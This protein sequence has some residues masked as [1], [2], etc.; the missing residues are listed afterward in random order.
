MTPVSSAP[1]CPPGQQEGPQWATY[2]LEKAGSSTTFLQGPLLAIP[3]QVR[4]VP[5]CS[6]HPG[7]A[8]AAVFVR[9]STLK[10]LELLTGLR[11]IDS[12]KSPAVPHRTGSEPREALWAVT[13]WYWQGPNWNCRIP[14]ISGQMVIW[15]GDWSWGDACSGVSRCRGRWQSAHGHWPGQSLGRWNLASHSEATVVRSLPV[16][17]GDRMGFFWLFLCRKCWYRPSR[18]CLTLRIAWEGGLRGG[19]SAD[20]GKAENQTGGPGPSHGLQVGAH[21]PP[22]PRCLLGKCCIAH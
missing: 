18:F 20:R 14:G 9:L 12:S 7:Q 3:G 16:D 17:P 8:T 21:V 2:G 22:C 10:G 6:Q 4:C 5:G 15:G 11:S 19:I 13:W 1:A